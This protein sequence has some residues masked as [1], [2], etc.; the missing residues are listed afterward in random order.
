M[1]HTLEKMKGR[2]S[3]GRGFSMLIHDYFQSCQY[4]VLS[5]RAVKLL[6]DMYCQF[7]GANN[8]DLCA[9]MSIMRKA[10]WTSCDQLRKALMELL[11]KGWIIVTRQGGRRRPT[12][13]GVTFLPIDECGGKL[14]VKPTREALHL[15]KRPDL[16][17]PPKINTTAIRVLRP[18]EHT[19]PPGG[20]KLAA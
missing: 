5:S 12:L 20:S 13:Y 7:R 19:A 3:K 4:A 9:T 6:I 8:G 18:T 16:R 14:D 11:E 2:S 10:G 15:W 1:A 17:H